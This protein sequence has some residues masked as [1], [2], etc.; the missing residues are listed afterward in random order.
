MQ[1]TSRVALN[2]VIQYLQLI[3]NVLLGLL[4]VRIVLASLG[5]SD[6]G[7]YNVVAGVVTLL[8]FVGTSLSQ[9]SIRFLSVSLGKNDV[10][11][12]RTTFQRCFWLHFRMAALL[13]L[14]LFGAG[15]FLFD[16]F[17][18]IPANRIPTARMVYVCMLCSLF[19]GIVKTPFSALLV[20]QEHFVFIA[21]IGMTDSICKLLVALVVSNVMSDKLAVYGW[22]MAGISVLDFIC[23]ATYAK[24]RFS[25]MVSLRRTSFQSMGEVAGFPGWTLLDVM[26]SVLNRQ[27]YA[28]LLNRYFGPVT[29]SV[30][31]LASQVEGHM[32]TV[33]ASVINAMKPQI[34]KSQGAGNTERMF[35]LSMTAGKFGYSL[36]ALITIPLI[37][38]LP[39]VLDL[40]LEKV[41]EGTA[42]FARLMVVACMMEQLT[43]GLV[44]ANQAVGNI[45]W[46]SIIVSGLRMMALPLSWA[47]FFFFHAPAYAA[48]IIFV[49]CET[50]GSLSRVIVLAR[51]SDFNPSVFPRD[52]L[53]RLLLPTLASIAVCVLLYSFMGGVWGM[54]AVLAVSACVYLA[55]FYFCGLTVMEKRS[56]ESL[57]AA[58]YRKT[59]RSAE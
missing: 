6:Y 11:H 22:L 26:G 21:I 41:P 5:E 10:Q 27:G 59:F 36:M 49:C 54:L 52:V 24:L 9:T 51:I 23:Y 13:I 57:V 39:E 44:H 15:L 42:L 20:A 25:N 46:F 33:S 29:N 45:K 34:M 2:T 32:Y 38:M 14:L 53:F 1:T 35:R 56:V 48:I 40:W 18:N 50:I 16:G 17:L 3:I 4:T 19:L 37:V 31:A 43:R 47:A 28:V 12:T 7:V 30:F 58:F 55:V 8:S